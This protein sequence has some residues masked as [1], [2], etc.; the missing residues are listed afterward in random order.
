MSGNRF[1]SLFNVGAAQ[2]AN[3]ALSVSF[4]KELSRDRWT[5]YF[6][7]LKRDGGGTRKDMKGY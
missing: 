6:L 7:A 3:V 1:S 2:K 4:E 5:G